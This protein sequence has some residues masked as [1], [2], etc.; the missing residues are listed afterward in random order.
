[1]ARLAGWLGAA[2]RWGLG[3]CALLLVLAALYVSLGRELMPWVAD[4]RAEVE[5]KAQQALGLPLTIGSLEGRWHDFAPVL[6]AHDVQIGEGDSLVRLDQVRVVPDVL[7]SLLEREPRLSALEVEGLQ[8]SLRQH[9]DGSWAL[10][11]L[12]ARQPGSAP[13]DLGQVLGQ[14]KKIARLSLHDS[15]FTLE[16]LDAA[17]V[18]FTY[19]NLSLRSGLRQRLDGRLTL[20]DG[21]PLALNLRARLN[22]KAWRQSSAELYVSLPQSDWARWLPESLMRGWRLKHLQA[23]GELWLSAAGGQLQR[24]V[25]RLHAPELTGAYAERKP[26][27]VQDLALNAYF[28]RDQQ[29]FQL[30]FDSLAMSL[31]ENR[32][33]EA[34][35]GLTQRAA[36]G[37]EGEHWQLSAD[38]LE[39]GPLLPLV[40]ALAPLPES[41]A[42]YLA[43]LQPQGTLR[44]LQLDYRPQAELAQ[45]LQFASNLDHLGIEAYKEIPAAKNVS[46]SL[47]GDLGQGELR[48]ATDNFSLHLHHLFPQ[49]W[50]YRQANAQ[51][52]WR[53]D[54]QAFTLRSPY[55]QLLGEEGKLAGDM[56]IRLMRDPAAEDYMDLRVG[57]RDG[58][59]RYTEKYLPTLSPGF[60]PQL[61]DW[62][63]SAIRA[64]VVDQG[65]FQ[66]QGSLNK[67]AEDTARSIS[68]FFKTHDAELAF[69]PGWPRLRQARGE[70]FIEDAGVR[71]QLAEG[72]LL[73]SRVHDVAV[74]VP[75]V[76]SGQ[77]P[78]LLL[79]GELESSVQDGLKI[80]QEAPIGTAAIFAGWQGEGPLTGKLKLDIPLY[81]GQA[82]D[83]GVDFATQ[84]ARLKLAS[85]A[86]ELSQLQG[87]FNFNSASGLSAP[88]IRAQVFG[89]PVR[90]KAVVAGGRGRNLTRIEATGQV[91]LQ[92]LTDWLAVSQPL[93]LSGSLPYR[94]ELTLS[95][96]DS[97]LRIGS[98]LKGLAIDLPPPFGKAAEQER[99]AQWRM[100]LQGAERRYW[101][102]Y[103]DLASLAV[104][105]PV[106]EL[107]AGRGELLLGGGSASLPATQGLRVKGRLSELDWGAW[108]VLAKR[109]A[110]GQSDAAKQLLSSADL[111]IDKFQ[112]FGS[113][114]DGL[115]VQLARGNASWA[116]NLASS[117]VTG[118]LVLPDSG[119][120]P[121]AVNLE[122]LRLPAA[123]PK[124]Q[125]EKDAPDPLAAVDPR[126]IPALDIQIAQVLQGDSPLG[127]WAL[128]ARPTPKGV[129]FN[130]LNLNLKGLQVSG[131]A[132]WEGE[133]GATSSWYKGRVKGGNLAD[134]LQA[135][136]FA[137]NVT[138]QSFRLDA[139]GR[140]PGSPAWISLKRFSGSLDP[141]LRKGQFVEVEGGAQALRVFGLLNFNSIGRRLRLDFSDILGKGLSYDRVEGLLVGSEGVY[142]T[143]E[144]VKLTGPSSNL[145]LDGTLDM[146]NDRVNAKLLV[147]LPLTNN[148]PLAALIVG[149][150]A[151]GGAL[152]VVDKLLGNR[153]ARFASVQYGVT[154]SWQN[155][156]ISF[157][158]P[159]EKP[160]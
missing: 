68:L 86:L 81:K 34:Q 101:L 79:N 20:P 48:L 149:A 35:L 5:S 44:N 18:S 21:Q 31:G 151:I 85:P 57:M 159:F 72:R 61:A 47:A 63:K 67:G 147:T 134:V 137:P 10:E 25:L 36:R 143:R 66:Y 140:W 103:A 52:F 23:G 119:V 27:T 87:A 91:A 118:R 144:P 83:V 112:G 138:S 135:W 15:Q 90:A 41:A 108:Q 130:E 12:P 11:G 78:H 111:Q 89:R 102:D 155:P 148:L 60:S 77:V 100:T 50:Q 24:G 40:Q 74:A 80:L 56:L 54:D 73:D 70:V 17:P 123:E 45:R 37:E 39:L 153:V 59:A 157:Q 38:R 84:G 152:F 19:V 88:D 154:G 114:L 158:K 120:A 32:W 4:Y 113:S 136:N 141:N 129:A 28:T 1:M 82:P 127:A 142:V 99:T 124:A 71:V 145:E 132:G 131:S 117:Q 16:P 14:L 150:P 26:V 94:L 95:G 156:K 107:S 115:K 43:G 76:E 133:P 110:S 106:G 42:A 51:L 46:G 58:D 49:S 3:L 109:Y 69:Q 93:P 92:S 13:L 29:G 75:H 53:L 65:Y 116:V 2:L 104:A 160:R 8:L 30:L 98:T 62:L 6:Y 126:Q 146:A 125:V 7:A 55:L 128:K 121:I 33:G 64:G 139:D 97:Q 122:R 96:A 105:A 22:A 9:D